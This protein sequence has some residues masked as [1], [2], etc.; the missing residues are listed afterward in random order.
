M[1]SL[2]AVSAILI[3]YLGKPLTQPEVKKLSGLEIAQMSYGF[4]DKMRRGDGKYNYY[5]ICKEEDGLKECDILKESYIP[6]NAWVMLA[7]LGLYDVTGNQKYLDGAK[8]EMDVLLDNCK[9]NDGCLWTLVQI[10]KLYKMAGDSA[11]LDKL[12]VF[13]DRLIEITSEKGAMMKG[14]EARQF[15][16]VYGL[17]GDQKYLTESLNRLESGKEYLKSEQVLYTVN[18]L[19]VRHYVCSEEIAK[20]ELYKVTGDKKYLTAVRNFFDAAEIGSHG[21]NFYGLTAIQPCIE[22]LFLLYRETGDL[23]YWEQTYNLTQYMITYR[24]DSTLEEAE[25]YN[26]D[27]AFLFDNYQYNNTKT[28]TDTG[29]AIYL[30]SLFKDT[31]F[32]IVSWR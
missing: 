31:E 14:I 13:A 10:S 28:V 3:L 25:K 23:K 26:G 2:I 19:D 22:T 32:N 30:L 24:W 16:I 7:N 17:T 12:K 18:G 15:A 21:R 11:Y 6:T 8:N 20:F 4:F 1:I 5:E 29:Y 9:D 27:G